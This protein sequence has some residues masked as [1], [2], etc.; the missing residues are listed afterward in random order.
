M[1]KKR[2]KVVARLAC[3]LLL[4]RYWLTNAEHPGNESLARPFKGSL[5]ARAVSLVRPA[6]VRIIWAGEGLAPV[7]HR[8]GRLVVR[9][10]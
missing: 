10:L 6:W 9:A 7:I 5:K 2:Q 1:A 4:A 3:G 8:P